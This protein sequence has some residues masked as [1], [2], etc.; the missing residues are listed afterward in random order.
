MT[1]DPWLVAAISV[2][3]LFCYVVGFIVGWLS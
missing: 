3:G 2:T 1:S